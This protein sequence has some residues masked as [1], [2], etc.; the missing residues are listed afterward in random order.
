MTNS[1]LDSHR[2]TIFKHM[3]INV[4]HPRLGRLVISSVYIFFLFSVLCLSRE[5]YWEHFL[6]L[7][8]DIGFGI[9]VNHGTTICHRSFMM[10]LHEK[11]IMKGILPFPF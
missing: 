2:K 7:D 1:N 6:C 10:T 4:T 9:W 11:V 5:A 8:L 3:A